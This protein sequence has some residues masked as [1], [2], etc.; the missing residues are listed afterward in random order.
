MELDGK[1]FREMKLRRHRSATFEGRTVTV[2]GARQ[3]GRVELILSD[4]VQEFII[5][6]PHRDFKAEQRVHRSID[7][8]ITP[9]RGVRKQAPLSAE[10]KIAQLKKHK[11]Y[12]APIILPSPA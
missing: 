5:A 11:V 8:A 2:L 4:S 9:K 7:Q 1:Q 3:G 10:R 6:Y 12:Y